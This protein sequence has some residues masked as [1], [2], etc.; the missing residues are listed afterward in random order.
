[1]CECPGHRQARQRPVR[2]RRTIRLGVDSVNIMSLSQSPIRRAT[3]I[4]AAV[5]IG[6]VLAVGAG[7]DAAG[8]SS[9]G[10]IHKMTFTG[11]YADGTSHF[12]GKD[13]EHPKIGDEFLDGGPIRQH[14]KIVGRFD[15]TCQ[16]IAGTNAHNLL[17]HCSGS[18]TLH[19]GQIVTNG[20]DNSSD[21]TTDAVVG[22]TGRYAYITGTAQSISG[23]TSVKIVVRYMRLR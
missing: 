18:L 6:T 8:A 17:T 21:D 16:I 23:S 7:P 12:V 15:D 1:M 3:L 13:P 19:H 10:V 22:G 5:G 2:T 9:M 11:R 4:A 20:V 14:G